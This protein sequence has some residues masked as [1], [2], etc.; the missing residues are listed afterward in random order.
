[1]GS[2]AFE[3]FLS[4]L[5]RFVRERLVPAEQQVVETDRIP[6]DI[7]ADMRDMGLFGITVPPEYGCSGMN[8]SQYIETIKELSWAAPAFR[9]LISINVCMAGSSIRRSG[10]D[11]QKSEWLPRIAAGD[12][13]AFALTDPDSGSDSAALR[14][15]A[16]RDGDGYAQRGRRLALAGVSSSRR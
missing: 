7:I 12:V 8:L 1:M 14:T 16:V 4:Q 9:S 15:T 6:E 3:I 2:E 5:K 11:G 10:T 13:V